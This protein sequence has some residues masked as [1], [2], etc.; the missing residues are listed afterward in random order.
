MVGKF[1]PVYLNA[2]VFLEAGYLKVIEIARVA[3]WDA[4]GIAVRLKPVNGL[5]RWVEFRTIARASA[6][7]SARLLVTVRDT[8]FS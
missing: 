3:Y 4:K 6:A 1:G 8:A 2:G 5:G 7:R